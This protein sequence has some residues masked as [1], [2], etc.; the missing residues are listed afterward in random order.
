MT[1]T[2]K[3]LSLATVS[4]T[5]VAAIACTT[6]PRAGL[7]ERGFAE[8]SGAASIYYERTGTGPA[9]VLIHGLGGNHAVW[10]RQVPRLSQSYSVVT[11]SQRGFAPS[12]GDRK[13]LDVDE[14]VDDV[15]AVLNL[16]DIE[17]A[18]IVGQS[19]GGWTALA[20]ALSHPE[21][22]RAV[23]LADSI[24]G[25][26]DEEISK[27][28]EAVAASARALAA[29]PPPLG[30]HPALDPE[31]SEKHP[32]EGYLYQLLTTFGSPNPGDVAGALG[33]QSIGHERLA[34]NRVP[35]LFVVGER[36]RLFPPQ[37]I[38]RASNLL[39][40]SEVKV[41]AD[42]GHSPYYEKPERWARIVEAFLD[43]L[44]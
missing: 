18:A 23:V 9:V 20:A 43:D 14:M 11:I 21:R 17:E 10:Y 29:Q 6:A 28:Y 22:V 31:F 13:T 25:I 27:H 32:E 35:T 7:R 16:L 12:S 5:T 42:T 44:E 39:A 3:T 40:H 4:L 37:L 34:A 41:I 19:M 2:A 1:M 30:F 33:R 15:V 36:D 8:R 24:G 38:A 26:F